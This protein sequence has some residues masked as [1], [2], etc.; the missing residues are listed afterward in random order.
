MV[1]NRRPVR[2]AKPEEKP[3]R[4]AVLYAHGSTDNLTYEA[5]YRPP[6]IAEGH[7]VLKVKASSLN[8]HDVFTCRGM[9][10]IKVPLPVTKL[11]KWKTGIQMVALGSE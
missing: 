7:V 4:A 3:M 11:A 1:F 10:G 8:Y 6:E 5:D 2:H 9:P